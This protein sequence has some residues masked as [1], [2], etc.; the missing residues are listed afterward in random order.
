MDKRLKEMQWGGMDLSEYEKR[1]AKQN[2]WML[3]TSYTNASEDI[4]GS[5][6]AEATMKARPGQLV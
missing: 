5:E 1:A 3:F 2:S 4:I 6:E